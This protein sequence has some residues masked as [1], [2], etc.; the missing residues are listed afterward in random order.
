MKELKGIAA[1]DGIAIAKA[2]VVANPDLTFKNQSALDADSEYQ[3]LTTAVKAARAELVTIKDKTKKDLGLSEAEVFDAHMSILKDPEIKKQIQTKIYEE[4]LS[5]PA[6]VQ[7]VTD[8]YLN[9]FEQLH[10]QN[11]LKQRIIDI[12]DVSKRVLG[13]LLGIVSNDLLLINED[14]IVIDDELTPSETAQLNPEFVKGVV[15]N[16]GGPTSHS[17]IMSRSLAIPS[18][19]GANRAN[20]EINNGDLVIVDGD[21]GLVIINPLANQLAYYQELLKQKQAHTKKL[22]TF[23]TKQTTSMDGLHPRIMANIGEPDDLDHALSNGAEGIGLYRTEFLFMNQSHMPTEEEQFLEYK[24]VLEAMKDKP[25]TI[26]TLDVGGDKQID[27]LSFPK[28]ENPFLGYRAIRY[29]L[30]E[31]AIFKIQLRA[32][33]RASAYGKLSIMFPMVSTIDE[34]RAA[35]QIYEDERQSLIA[36]GVEVGMVQLGV[37]IEVPASALMAEQFATEVDFM[38]IGTN[39][40]IQYVMAT[41]RGNRNVSQ[42]YQPLNPAVLRIIKMVIDACHRNEIP[43]KICGEMAGDLNA[44]PILFGMGLD[45]FSMTPTSILKV[46]ELIGQMNSR[47]MITLVNQIMAFAKTSSDVSELVNKSL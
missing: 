40:L 22:Q 7:E 30:N 39:D 5:A 24:K 11:Y 46:R 21:R 36:A 32:L 3:L 27:Y 12:Q 34:F 35:K 33:L 9:L 2:F 13:H 6:A 23:Q 41:D 8:W 44:V 14:V 29:S 1:S 31:P 19:M 42:L 37:M 18:V 38:S 28:E 17:A 16:H 47:K 15:L 26:R 45:D 10:D 43:A 25:V 4:H 20:K